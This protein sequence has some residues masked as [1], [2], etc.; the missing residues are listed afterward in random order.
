MQNT[1]KF[2]GLLFLILIFV[3]GIF[4][5]SRKET[6]DWRKNFDLHKKTPFG[7]YVFDQELPNLFGREVKT[8][9]VSP[10]EYYSGK[11]NL[12]KQNIM[13][14]TPEVSDE[15]VNKILEQVSNGS[16]AFFISEFFSQKILDTLHLK[17]PEY[18]NF[19]D[20][21]TLKLRD[22]KFKDIA[23]HL[24]KFPG[25]YAFQRVELPAEVL[26]ITTSDAERTAS[27]IKVNFGKGKV[28]MHTEPLFLTNFYLLK[29]GNEKYAESVFSYLPD[30]ETVIFTDS[31]FFQ[32]RSILRF[33]LANPPLKYAWWLLLAGLLIFVIFNAKR[34]QRIV[35][36]IEPLR[37]KSAEFVKSIGNLYLQEGDFHDMMAKKAQ[38]FLHRVRTELLLDTAELN[39]DFER[40]LQLKT[41]K[42]PE[43]IKEA[44]Q[45]IQKD[46]DPYAH[47]IRD[48]LFRLNT[49]L[50]EL[51]P[52]T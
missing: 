32:S 52:K 50:D 36:V 34:R 49:L 42:S 48:D 38:Y 5:V 39:E 44:I 40:K 12:R 21:N 7:L 45:L 9:T 16:E 37:N 10:Y 6:V 23:L 15:S 17:Y 18:A 20:T 22:D 13:V 4:Q 1:F 8:I 35:P 14:I 26:G 28:F 3:L 41:G 27:F 19:A 46:S 29:S 33:I 47:V 24:N 51:L 31:S 30:Q 25:R 2:Y 11:A 43:K